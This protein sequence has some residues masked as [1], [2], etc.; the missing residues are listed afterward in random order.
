M[1]KRRIGLGITGLADALAMCGLVYGSSEAATVAAR[2]MAVI[3]AESYR[4]S[5][6]LARERSSFPLFDPEQFGRSGHAS[7]LPRRHPSGDRRARHP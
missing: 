7:R 3:E 6:G 5:A 1:A 2:W 4:A